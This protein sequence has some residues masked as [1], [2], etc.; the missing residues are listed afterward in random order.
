M[1]LH[2]NAPKTTQMYHD[3]CI[4]QLW[5]FDHIHDASSYSLKDEQRDVTAESDVIP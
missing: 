1:Q 3:L 4:P 2:V 5:I